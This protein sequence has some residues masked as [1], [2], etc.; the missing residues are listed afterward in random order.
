M[1]FSDGGLTSNFPDPL[2]R[3]PLPARP[4]FGINLVPDTVETTE[5]MRPMTGWIGRANS[6]V[7]PPS[8]QADPE[9][10]HYVCMAN[11]NIT[12]IGLLPASTNLTGGVGFSVRC[13]TP[14]ATG[15][16]SHGPARLSR[17]RRAREA[18]RRRRRL[19]SQYAAEDHRSGGRARRAGRQTARRSAW[20]DSSANEILIDPKLAR[21]SS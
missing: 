5:T 16:M 3:R 12:G 13:S 7:A 20:A 18:R 19:K 9:N 17:P 2:L 4:T 1:W 10:W 8:G 15:V 14:R 11:K 21:P 6:N